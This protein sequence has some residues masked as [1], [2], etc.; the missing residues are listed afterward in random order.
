MTSIFITGASSGLGRGLSLAFAEPGN[1][2]GLFA[3]REHELESLASEIQQLGAQ[4]T[5]YVGDVREQS[6]LEAAI[7]G[8]AKT[9]GTLD[10]VIANA[11]TGEGTKEERLN[12]A[13][14]EKVIS[15]NLQGV[16]NTLYPAARLMKQQGHGTLVGMSSVAAYGALPG[17]L[18]YSPTKAAVKVLMKGLS[19]ELSRAGVSTVCLCPGFVRTPLTDKNQFSMP[20]ISETEDACR[21]MK[22][23]II[24]KNRI[25]TF[26]LV[27]LL[28]AQ[29]LRVA[30]EW[31]LHRLSPKRG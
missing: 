20:F 25:F 5:V 3:R 14:A 11:G 22:R 17:S 31:L 16:V 19:L 29:L 4:P 6:L 26:P 10:I 21:R 28:L 30:P 23:A 1:Q 27:F 24:H 15:L 13:A 12:A 7:F 8:F 18:I 9:A 2:I